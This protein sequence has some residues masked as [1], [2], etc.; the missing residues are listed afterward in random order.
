MRSEDASPHREPNVTRRRPTL[1]AAAAMTAV[2][3]FS[4]SACG[5]DDGG[6]KSDEKIEGAGQGS[7]EKSPSPSA[8]EDQEQGAERPKIELPGD[9]TNTFT[10]EKAGDPVQDEILGDN[11]EFVRALDAAIAAGDPELPALAFYTEGE[12]AASAHQWVKSFKDKGLTI[13]GTTRYYDRK[14]K[15]G[16]ETTASLTYCADESK[17]FTKDI[18][19][20]KVKETKVTKDSYVVYGAQVR[21]NKDG[22]WELIKMSS[23]RGASVCRP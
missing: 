12:A 14:V 1:L 6:S 9:V 19:T 16:S 8:P 13:T 5:G 2:T 10:P 3:V 20:K 4:L 15:V 7:E 18:K 21:K 11:A 23:T 17:A 22:V